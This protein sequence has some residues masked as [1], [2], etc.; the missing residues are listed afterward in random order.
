[1][2]KF[3]VVLCGYSSSGKDSILQKMIKNERFT[4]LVSHTTRPIR[5]ETEKNGRDY[6]FHTKESFDKVK[7]IETRVYNTVS[8]LWW[9][10]LS[11]AELKDK[12]SNGEIPVVILDFNGSKEFGEWCFENGVEAMNIYIHVPFITR[13]F[14]A[15]KRGNFNWKEWIRREIADRKSFKGAK[16]SMMV[17]NNTDLDKCSNSIIGHVFK[18]VNFREGR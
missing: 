5:S 2:K 17:V 7:M 12:L 13:T 6:Y 11:E 16:N 15:Y 1:M 9:Y 8:G 4:N 18:Y 3:V 14:R 10:G